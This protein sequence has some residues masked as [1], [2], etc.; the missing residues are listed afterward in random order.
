LLIS[1]EI[2]TKEFGHQL[3]ASSIKNGFVAI[4][5]SLISIVRV[6]PHPFRLRRKVPFV[7]IKIGNEARLDFSLASVSA[8]VSI[9]KLG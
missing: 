5:L 6:P 4:K 3:D 2:F 1:K 9:Q 7:G 8:I